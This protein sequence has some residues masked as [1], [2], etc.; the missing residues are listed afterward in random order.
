MLE[1]QQLAEK[2][3][4]PMMM[5]WTAVFIGLQVLAGSPDISMVQIGLLV[6][7]VIYPFLKHRKENP[8]QA[9]GLL[10]NQSKCILFGVFLAS[11]ML[12][13]TMEWLKQSRRQSGLSASETLTLSANWYDFLGVV[14]PAPLGDM[15]LRFSEFRRLIMPGQMLPYVS[16]CYLGPAVI[17]SAIWSLF[18]KQWKT[19]AL[20][21]LVLLALAV[22]A[23][24]QN[25]PIMPLILS[26]VNLPIRFPVKHMFFFVGLVSAF[27]AKGIDEN[28]SG[29]RPFLASLFVWICLLALGAAL[30]S[31]VSLLPFSSIEVSQSIINQA[32]AKISRPCIIYSIAGILLSLLGCLFVWRNLPMKCFKICVLIGACLSLFLFPY[33]HRSQQSAA[34]S[35]FQNDS[36][37][38]RMIDKHLAASGGN[39]KDEYRIL[40][41]YLEH[42]TVPATVIDENNPEHDNLKATV[43]AY[44]YSRQV[45]RPNTNMDFGQ[46][47]SFGFEAS[48]TGDYFNFLQN[49]YAKSSQ[50]RGVG[51]AVNDEPIAQLCLSTSTRF[52]LTQVFRYGITPEK[53]EAIPLLDAKHFNLLNEDKRLNVRLYETK[54][55][56]KRAYFCTDWRRL[57]SH[58]E[59]LNVM[60][61]PGPNNFKPVS[62]PL[63]ELDTGAPG[64]SGSSDANPN[65]AEEVSLLEASNNRVR[66]EVQ[67]PKAGY[68]VLADQFYEGWCAT[69]DGVSAP[70]CR[71][72]SF[73]R[74]VSLQPGRHVVDF[75]FI[76]KGFYAGLLIALIVLAYMLSRVFLMKTNYHET[77]QTATES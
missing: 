19:K 27:A 9:K 24:G 75:V 57:A 76:P 32:N 30:A 35:Y 46:L 70:I 22:L 29:Y 23:L 66:I 69:V 49:C 26:L 25:T 28:L 73:F 47:S 17:S 8:T 33:A 40:G 16:S 21:A 14:L 53:L 12:L 51:D 77:P 39:R 60:F 44:Q 38:A 1:L 2:K 56:T 62:Q 71:A 72:N 5:F 64:V 34:G 67:T 55:P 7:A 11:P 3:N 6:L 48:C 20:A 45:L 74:A 43:N 41:L 13:P 4:C 68:L 59:A 50:A 65:L 15:Q 42:F 36:A 61:E 58:D 31:N 37:V 18:D 63:I 54:V 10:I 52:V